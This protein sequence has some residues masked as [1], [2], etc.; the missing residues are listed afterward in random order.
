MTSEGTPASGGPKPTPAVLSNLKRAFDGTWRPEYGPSGPD[1]E[2]DRVSLADEI[3][4]CFSCHPP[5]RIPADGLDH[6]VE[7]HPRFDTV[8]VIV[9]DAYTV[10]QVGRR[11]GAAVYESTTTVSADGQSRTETWPAAMP[12]DGVLVPV[13]APLVGPESARRPVMFGASAIR[14]GA[15]EEGAHLVSGRW[16]VVAMDLI[17]HDEDTVYAIED[18][19]LSMSDRLGRSFTAPLDGTRAPYVGDPRVTSVSVRA[20]DDRTIEETDLR[21]GEIV[22]TIRWQ[23]DPD[24]RTMRVRFDDGHG[25]VMEQSGHRV[26]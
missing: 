23:V 13:R 6:A 20:I 17:D 18:A 7:G 5:Y 26:P 21:D 24:G 10:R 3:Y 19:A 1:R 4:E 8:A 2:P 15:V 22:Q 25:H 9:V 11:D 16:K 14:V 12:V